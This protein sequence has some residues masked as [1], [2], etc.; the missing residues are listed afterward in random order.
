MPL[1]Q[2]PS[3]KAFKSNVRKEMQAGKPQKQALA[4]AYS[5]KRA[6]KAKGGMMKYAQG[7]MTEESGS[8]EVACPDCQ[9]AGGLCES[10]RPTKDL[11]PHRPN[12]A[13]GGMVDAERPILGSPKRH[14]SYEE[15]E[16]SMQSRQARYAEG[17]SVNAMR[18]LETDPQDDN[19][20]EHPDRE[21]APMPMVSEGMDSEEASD[22]ERS[23]P[24]R[25]KDLSLSEE[26]MMD[27]KRKLMAK[28]GMAHAMEVGSLQDAIDAPDRSDMDNDADELDAPR[29]DGREDRGLNLEPVHTMEDS[30]HDVSDASLVSD[31][32][33][34]R[35]RRRRE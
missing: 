34:D 35:K 20:E 1:V 12:H 32:L 11:L 28:G 14:N 25:S 15:D 21:E 9:M 23:M 8:Q 33:R 3:P 4:I 27:R 24:R 26:I 22:M 7:G 5:T 17:G 10:H 30:E 19:E 31:I 13:E 29:E 2:S 18:P 6:N 16:M